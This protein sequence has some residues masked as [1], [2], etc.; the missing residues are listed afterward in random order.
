M[1]T[2]VQCNHRVTVKVRLLAF[3]HDGAK[4]IPSPRHAYGDL[5]AGF[6]VGVTDL[7]VTVTDLDHWA[8][9]E[10]LQT[11]YTSASLLYD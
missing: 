11:L 5:T 10:A 2:C 9:A 3:D 6:L 8:L 1:Y 7:S 4:L